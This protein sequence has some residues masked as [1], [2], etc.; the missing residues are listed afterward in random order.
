MQHIQP[1][2]LHGH[3]I[4]MSKQFDRSVR[5]TQCHKWLWL[6]V[7]LVTHLDDERIVEVP[8]CAFGQSADQG[9]ADCEVIA[10]VEADPESRVDRIFPF[11][12]M[13]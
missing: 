3:A 7:M 10:A 9:A 2:Q 8:P 4:R 6:I 1:G 13:G 5:V 12:V 11:L